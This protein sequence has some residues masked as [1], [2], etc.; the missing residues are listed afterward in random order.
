MPDKRIFVLVGNRNY[1]E[2]RQDEGYAGF[3]DL[4]SV[5]SD[6]ANTKKGLMDFGVNEEDIIEVHDA[7][8]KKFS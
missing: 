1:F 6:I 7:D 3:G 5:L 8:F 2:R 4:P